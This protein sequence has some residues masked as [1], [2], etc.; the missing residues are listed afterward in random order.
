MTAVIANQ[1]DQQLSAKMS[2][3]T[4]SEKCFILWLR[5]FSVLGFQLPRVRAQERECEVENPLLLLGAGLSSW[6]RHWDRG[7]PLPPRFSLHLSKRTNQGQVQQWRNRRR[8]QRQDICMASKVQ[9]HWG[10][11]E[12]IRDNIQFQGKI[13]A[14]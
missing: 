6:M 5:C 9:E 2:L 11:L 4:F 13:E 10:R 7:N 12:L 14:Q 8:K 1:Y 3:D